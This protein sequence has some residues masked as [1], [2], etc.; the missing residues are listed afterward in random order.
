M[1]D[2]SIETQLAS[3]C[4]LNDYEIEI[5]EIIGTNNKNSYVL[6]NGFEILISNILIFHQTSAKTWRGYTWRQRPAMKSS[7]ACALYKPTRTLNAFVV[8]REKCLIW[9]DWCTTI[10]CD[11][12]ANGAIRIHTATERY[13]LHISVSFGSA[14]LCME[15]CDRAQ[16]TQRICFDRTAQSIS[17]RLTPTPL[18]SSEVPWRGGLGA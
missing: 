10:S 8:V 1:I 4:V 6:F 12:D 16:A 15:T 9:N 2:G 7:S 14:Q 3:L 11:W 18:I 5:D 17:L 13:P